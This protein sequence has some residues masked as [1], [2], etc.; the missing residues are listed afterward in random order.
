MEESIKL[1]KDIKKQNAEIIDNQKTLIKQNAM[2]LKEL[3][4]ISTIQGEAHKVDVRFYEAG[5]EI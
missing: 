4:K 5:K 1:L 2:M 3:V